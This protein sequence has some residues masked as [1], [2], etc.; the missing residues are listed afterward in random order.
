MGKFNFDLNE[1]RWRANYE[2]GTVLWEIDPVNHRE[3][4][5]G[6]IVQSKLKSFDLMLSIKDMDDVKISETDIQVKTLDETPAIISL[7]LYSKHSIPFYHL[8]LQKDQRIIFV[9]RTQKSQ[10]RKV[11]II[12]TKAG[13][14]KIPFPIPTGQRIV[15]IGWQKKIGNENIQAIN[16]I[17]PDGRI[18][19]TGAWGEDATHTKVN[20]PNLKDPLEKITLDLK[21]TSISADAVLMK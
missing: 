2:D 15:I 5:F 10:G 9:R 13:E 8:E 20:M 18:E 12:P 1:M 16:F 7:K 21:E 17:F 19:M 4:K 6:E 3:H 14:I 11:A